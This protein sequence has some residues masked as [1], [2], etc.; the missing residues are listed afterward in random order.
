MIKFIV[1]FFFFILYA[2]VCYLLL[3][4]LAILAVSALIIIML[5]IIFVVMSLFGAVATYDTI[6][7]FKNKTR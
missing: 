2:G 5:G 1:G 6:Y 4:L 7:N 3:W